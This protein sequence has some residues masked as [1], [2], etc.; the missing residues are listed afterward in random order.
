MK[1]KVGV[2]GAGVIGVATAVWLQREGFDVML[3]D[4]QGPGEATS[5]GNG[6]VLASCSVVP[7]TVPG[8]GR[9]VPRLLLGR[10]GPLF[11]RWGY[12]PSLLPW[13]ARYLAQC[14]A[15]A[16]ERAARALLPLIGD[17]L[18]EHQALAA[19]T[20]AERW[21]V[22][23][24]YL[25]LYRT[26][27]DFARDRFGWDLRRK[28]GIHWRELAAPEVAEYDPTVAPDLR[29]AVR[30]DGHGR[31][32]DPGAYVKALAEHV[33]RSG[34]QLVRAEVQG[35]VQ[36]AGRV[37]GLRACGDTIACDA[38][39]VAAGAWSAPLAKSLGLRVPLQSERG[40]HLELWDPSAMPR[41]PAMLAAAKLVVTPMEGRIR[42]AGLVEF[43][44]LHA[45]A[46]EA[47]LA[48]LRRAAERC[49]PT[50]RWGET[51]TWMGHRP[52]VPDSIPVIG[53]VPGVAGAWLGFGH[54]HVGLTA[55]AATGRLLA[56]LVAGRRPNIDLAP[57]APTRFQ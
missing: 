3:V 34:G 18:S 12:L 54:H 13:L 55:A 41:A 17:S 27:A 38:A 52:A 4:R 19:G 30:L 24:D 26:R 53:A 31:I 8:L 37:V 48:L 15:D 9:S 20:G 33:V 6:G 23:S 51:R 39:I 36:E 56:Q 5:H 22:P 25:Y 16:C 1:R 45:P 32:A 29:F 14:N 47:P 57:Y 11:L 46:S 2:V 50:L 43:G 40:Y 10:D 35:I 28:L 21:I 42:L 44:G 49:L 7:V